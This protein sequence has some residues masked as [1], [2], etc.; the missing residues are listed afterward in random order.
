MTEL[1]TRLAKRA[2]DLSDED[3]AALASVLLRS[4]SPAA[5]EDIDRL[6]DEEAE[7]RV[8]EIERGEVE[9]LDGEQVLAE[10]RERFRG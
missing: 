10:L 5:Q 9:L 3:R 6:W 2:L 8:G 4:L 7:R 1:A